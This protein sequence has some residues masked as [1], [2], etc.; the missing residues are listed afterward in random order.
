MKDEEQHIDYDLLGKYLS[1]ESS[2][3]EAR[4]V[5]TWKT[6]SKANQDEFDRLARLWRE[7]DSLI[8]H[9][10]APVNLDA[11][12]DNLQGRIFGDEEIPGRSIT[13][14]I[15]DTA[16]EDIYAEK[17]GEEALT[18]TIGRESKVRDLYYY[19]SRI[20]AVLVVGFL[21]YS[22]FFMSG[23]EPDQVE[24]YADN[25]ITITDLP[26]ESKV[27]LNEKT[28][29]T[30]PEKFESEERAVELSG[31]AFFE[32]ERDEDKPFLV[33]AH[34]AVVRVL[35]TSFNVRAVEEETE[36]SV[37][38]EEG[39]VRLSDEEDIAFVI[40]EKNE[41]GI[42]NRDTGHIEKYEKSEGGE[43]FWRS[44]TVMFRDTEL[45]IVFET[46]EKLYDTEILTK[47]KDILSCMLSAK[48]QDMN[49]EE[50]LDKIA[51]NFNLTIEKNDSTFEI[52]GDGC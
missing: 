15:A 36:I 30:F 27:T 14:E 12:W 44:R 24:V 10:P 22:V 16:K 34:N 9:T 29:I 17:A 6:S 48:F 46:L 5:E 7:A 19:G 47:N 42:F 2:A 37:T 8:G 4:E 31:E 50:I 1:G 33:H 49:I 3:E 40:L 52:S 38:V 23:G 41:K 21:I 20:A 25:K 35:G 32:V 28:K 11:A 45:S 13:E 26:D 18:R 43:M 51:I 39:K